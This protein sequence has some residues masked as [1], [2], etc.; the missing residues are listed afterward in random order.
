MCACVLI[1]PGKSALPR[2]SYRSALGN[3]ASTSSV[4]PI[5]AMRL[6]ST[7]SATSSRTTSGLATV[8]FVKT[9]V[10][11]WASGVTPDGAP[12]CRCACRWSGF[13]NR[14]A[15]PA[16]VAASH[17][18]RVRFAELL[19]EW[20]VRTEFFRVVFGMIGRLRGVGER[21]FGRLSEYA[22]PPY[23][24]QAG[25][26]RARAPQLNT[27]E[28]SSGAR[29][30]M[31]ASCPQPRDE[32]QDALRGLQGRDPATAAHAGSPRPEGEAKTTA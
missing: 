6:P 16:P 11:S 28:L 20:W 12:P 13:T 7:A 27:E 26:R 30:S 29:S 15:V 25:S 31:T 32:G 24:Y 3:C 8:V 9:T 22:S 17:F 10:P 2:P 5:A 21:S 14:A 23:G 1:R 19:E 18:R 4:G